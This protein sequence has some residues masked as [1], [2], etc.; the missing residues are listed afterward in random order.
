MNSVKSKDINKD[1]I[2]DGRK[3]VA[4]DKVRVSPSTVVIDG[5]F[6]YHLF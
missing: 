5:T 1:I 2:I 6:K 3:E 4:I